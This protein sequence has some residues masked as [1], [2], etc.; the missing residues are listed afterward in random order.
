M[1][2]RIKQYRKQN[3]GIIGIIFCKQCIP[4]VPSLDKYRKLL[5]QVT[6]AVRK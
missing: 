5:I 4:Y 3:I 1:S 6:A 2:Q